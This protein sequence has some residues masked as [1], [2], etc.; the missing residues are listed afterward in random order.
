MRELSYFREQSSP[1]KIGEQHYART[2]SQRWG[3][4][5]SQTWRLSVWICDVTTLQTGK[6]IVYVMIVIT[7]GDFHVSDTRL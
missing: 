5:S 3:S 1:F 2:L 4:V 6:K 7:E